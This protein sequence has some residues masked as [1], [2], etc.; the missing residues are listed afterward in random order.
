[1][2]VLYGFNSYMNSKVNIYAT[3]TY[4]SGYLSKIDLIVE[5][6]LL[7]IQVDWCHVN[8]YKYFI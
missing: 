7:T 8:G 6:S 1:M 2:I 4:L 5:W 3:S